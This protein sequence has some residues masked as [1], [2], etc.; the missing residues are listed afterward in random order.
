MTDYLHGPTASLVRALLG[1]VHGQAAVTDE[2]VSRTTAQALSPV[3]AVVGPDP[4]ESG[5]GPDY[6]PELE[7]A[8]A[9]RA[10]LAEAE[11]AGDLA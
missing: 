3:P 7:T 6:P 11:A 2:M 9:A 5:A 8:E 4:L 10:E 1:E